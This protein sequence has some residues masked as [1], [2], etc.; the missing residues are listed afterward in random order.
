MT[1]SVGFVCEKQSVARFVV[2]FPWIANFK[3]YQVHVCAIIIVE[4]ALLRLIMVRVIRKKYYFFFRLSIC[5]NLTSDNVVSYDT[6]GFQTIPGGWNELGITLSPRR[7]RRKTF[8]T[9]SYE[10]LRTTFVCVRC[11]KNKNRKVE[12]NLCS[13]NRSFV[14]S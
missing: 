14:L 9:F 8:V 1:E 3:Q 11:R 10:Y 6:W 13:R 5:S 7:R 12:P 2:L 4:F